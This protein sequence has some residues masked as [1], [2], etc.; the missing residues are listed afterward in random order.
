MG[1]SSDYPLKAQLKARV[2]RNDGSDGNDGWGPARTPYRA[3]PAPVRRPAKTKPAA[4]KVV[5]KKAA[6]K[7]P[8]PKTAYE[9]LMGVDAF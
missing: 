5:K 7:V 2:W 1:P 3:P 8:K 9:R 6:R 4:K